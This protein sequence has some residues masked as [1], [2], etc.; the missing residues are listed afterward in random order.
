MLRQLWTVTGDIQRELMSERPQLRV[1]LSKL[2]DSQLRDPF[3]FASL[4]GNTATPYNTQ[5]SVIIPPPLQQTIPG[6]QGMF[7]PLTGLPWDGYNQQCVLSSPGY[8]P[9]LLQPPAPL[10]SPAWQQR[11]PHAPIPPRPPPLPPAAPMQPTPSRPLPTKPLPLPNQQRVSQQPKRLRPPKPPPP[12]PEERPFFVP[13][14]LQ[15][16]MPLEQGMPSKRQSP[17]SLAASAASDMDISSES[18][19]RVPPPPPPADT[20]GTPPKKARLHL[21]P[22]KQPAQKRQDLPI[23]S[24]ATIGSKPDSNQ[25]AAAALRT[26]MQPP[27]EQRDSVM[28]DATETK[29]ILD[30]QAASEAAAD[31]VKEGD[32]LSKQQPAHTKEAAPEPMHASEQPAESTL[33]LAVAGAA[34]QAMDN[35]KQDGAY[36]EEGEKCEDTSP[37]QQEAGQSATADAEVQPMDVSQEGKAIQ[38]LT[39]GE[40]ESGDIKLACMAAPKRIVAPLLDDMPVPD[41]LKVCTCDQQQTCIGKLS[42]YALIF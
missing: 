1:A 13:S 20:A 25:P 5:P 2:R 40:D 15:M 19:G 36:P 23:A 42:L 9:A 16:L 14:L 18:A 33:P 34:D 27:G 22:E 3:H 4:K 37:Q 30:E 28:E 32:P 24:E 8:V 7:Q 6:P 26:A 17:D 39:A 35:I 41:Y 38:A 12:P 21:G 11:Q 10:T 31:E 29:Q